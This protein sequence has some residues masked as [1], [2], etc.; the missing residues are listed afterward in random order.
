MDA[1]PSNTLPRP[2]SG[3]VRANCSAAR[4]PPTRELL[5]EF[6]VLSYPANI[7]S[8]RL[9]EAIGACV[10]L[11]RIVKENEIQPAQCLRHGAVFDPPAHDR[12]KALIERS[13]VS[14]FLQCHLRGDRVRR[15]HKRDCIGAADK[16]LNALP[17]ILERINLF[18]VDQHLKAARLQLGFKPIGERHVLARVGDEDPCLRL[19]LRLNI[20]RCDR[21]LHESAVLFSRHPE[22]AY[23][24]FA[25][26]KILVR[27]IGRISK[28]PNCD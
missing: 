18:A 21:I 8:K 25:P 5:A 28:K 11:L 23:K 9:D 20:F 3:G 1:T 24:T 10:E 12:R 4:P 22:A 17:P 27:A 2:T 15:Q 13:G 16:R 19:D 26:T 7:R 14:N 6:G